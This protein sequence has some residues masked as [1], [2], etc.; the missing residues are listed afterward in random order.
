VVIYR[1]ETWFSVV[2]RQG[3]AMRGDEGVCF[4]PEQIYLVKRRPAFGAYKTV[5]S[6]FFTLACFGE[7][8][9]ALRGDR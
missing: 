1:R 8:V 5:T 6:L 2:L 7:P 3:E 9:P 4:L